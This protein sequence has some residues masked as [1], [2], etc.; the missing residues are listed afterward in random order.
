MAEGLERPPTSFEIV[1]TNLKTYIEYVSTTDN[2][3][4]L[5]IDEGSEILALLQTR[6]SSNYEKNGSDA[7]E[8]KLTEW[9]SIATL[10]EYG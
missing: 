6:I 5:I 10:Y 9:I 4:R 1:N 3:K 8:S 2:D 7:L